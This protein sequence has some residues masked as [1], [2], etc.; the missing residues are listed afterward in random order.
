MAWFT[1]RAS[2]GSTSEFLPV[3]GPAHDQ[4]RARSP[5]SAGRHAGRDQG[6]SMSVGQIGAPGATS[7]GHDRTR[8]PA[9]ASP[10][11]QTGAT[12]EQTECGRG[13]FAPASNSE[14]VPYSPSYPASPD[15]LAGPQPGDR[16]GQQWWTWP[17]LISLIGS[18]SRMPNSGPR[19]ADHLV[20]G[21]RPT[22]LALGSD[23]RG[24]S[25]MIS[26]NGTMLKNSP[27]VAGP[28]GPDRSVR[29]VGHPVL[30]AD[31]QRL[32]AFRAQPRCVAFGF[33]RFHPYVALAV[34]VQMVF[35][36]L[37]KTCPRLPT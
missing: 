14:I 8:Q 23:G 20:D 19:H 26:G 10:L 31:G 34:A 22:G 2:D 17:C 37:G 1:I 29:Q 6:P 28:F 36:F 13:Q 18:S 12:V 25:P 15:H 4:Q 5:T 9:P 30:H 21:R 16:F 27:A 33:R 11:R 35:P 32:A 24:I 7:T 3:P